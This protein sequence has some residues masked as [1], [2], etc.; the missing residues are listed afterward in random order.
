MT[1]GAIHK[2]RHPLRGEEG[3]AKSWRYFISLFSKMGDKGERWVENLE[4][5]LTSSIDVP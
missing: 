3:S 2:W 4:K 1:F 5:L